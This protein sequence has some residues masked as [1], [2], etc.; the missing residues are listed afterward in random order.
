MKLTVK[1]RHELHGVLYHFNRALKYIRQESIAVAI[2]GNKATT[3]LHYSRGD[4]RT[5]YEVDKV[6]G[7]D[8]CGLEMGIHYLEG[9]IERHGK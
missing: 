6:I 5:L 7:S 1:Q 2:C 8:L 3:T 4:G 9:F